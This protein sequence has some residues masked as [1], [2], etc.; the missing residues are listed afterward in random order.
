MDKNIPLAEFTGKYG[1][2]CQSED[3]RKK[4]KGIAG[5]RENI[6]S[7]KKGGQCQQEISLRRNF[8][9]CF[10]ITMCNY[11]QDK[12]V[13]EGGKS[14]NEL[15]IRIQHFHSLYEWKQIDGNDYVI[16]GKKKR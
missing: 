12:I 9:F 2:L 10:N 16:N 8:S 3:G 4:V 5:N 6:N 7:S 13:A 14:L 15:G 1:K 11:L